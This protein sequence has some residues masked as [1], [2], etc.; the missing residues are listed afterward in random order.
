L[1]SRAQPRYDTYGRDLDY[2]NQEWQLQNY[3]LV[4]RVS[5]DFHLLPSVKPQ[6]YKT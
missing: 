4:P 1:Y 3:A 5:I 6:L 2:T